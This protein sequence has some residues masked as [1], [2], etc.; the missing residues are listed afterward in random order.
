VD[1]GARG[2]ARGRRP[3]QSSGH[4]RVAEQLAHACEASDRASFKRPLSLIG[5]P[6]IFLF[7]KIFK[8]PHFDIQIGD[9]L[10]VQNPPN[11]DNSWKHKEQLSFLA[12]L[13]IPKGLQVI[14][15]GTKSKLKL[16]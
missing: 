3:R 13:Q 8:Y 4:R 2:S 14:N 12:Q 1:K 10:D 15:S 6:N 5:G 16:P 9:L 11:F 7:I